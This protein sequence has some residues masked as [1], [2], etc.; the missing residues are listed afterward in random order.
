MYFEYACYDEI[1]VLNR[2]K[3]KNCVWWGKTDAGFVRSR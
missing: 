1:W 2:A 3:M